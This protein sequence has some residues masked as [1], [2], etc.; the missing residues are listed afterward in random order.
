KFLMSQR[1][2]RHSSAGFGG[3]FTDRS[4]IDGEFSDLMLKPML[5]DARRISGQARYLLGIDWRLV[6][7]LKSDHA[8]ITAPV[9]LV[10]GEDDKI[11][12]V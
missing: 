7:A 5:A 6:D 4:L 2:F 11:F 1:W 9:L 8:K 12:P 3:C 10:W